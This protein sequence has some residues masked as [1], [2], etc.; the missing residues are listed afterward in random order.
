MWIY[1]LFIIREELIV[2]IIIQFSAELYFHG[3]S[4]SE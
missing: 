2:V 1:Y 3:S 4:Q